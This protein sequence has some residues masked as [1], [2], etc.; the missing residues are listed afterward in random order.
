MRVEVA[1]R[2]VGQHQ[3]R[4]HGQGAGDGDALLLAAGQ[5]VGE[6][7]LA[8][9]QADLVEQMAGAFD[10]SASGRPRATSSGIATFSTAVKAGIRW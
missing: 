7:L 4:V 8:V 2:L 5:L 10:I 3:R 9:G 6:M 1:G